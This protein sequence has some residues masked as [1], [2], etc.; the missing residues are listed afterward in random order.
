MGDVGTNIDLT[1]FSLAVGLEN[2]E[3]EPE[4][5]PALVYRYQ[6]LTALIFSSGKVIL[7]GAIK[8]DELRK[9]F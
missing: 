6:K 8:T 3:Y 2:V 9:N 4:Q 7:T 1:K 5:F